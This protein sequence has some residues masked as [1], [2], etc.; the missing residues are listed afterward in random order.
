MNDQSASDISRPFFSIWTEP[1]ATIQH[2]IDSDPER[3]VLVL[4]AIGGAIEALNR[5]SSRS[6]GDEL[7]MGA[8]FMIAL[9]AGSIGGILSLYVVAGLVGWT[10]R[11]IGGV[12]TYKQIRAAIAWSF[13]PFL[14]VSLMWIPELLVFGEEMFTTEMPR[15]EA[16]PNLAYLLLAMV[17]VEFVGIIW[18]FV[19]YLHCLGQVQHFSAWRALGNVVIAALI[20]VV[21]TLVVVMAIYS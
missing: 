2:I 13:V 9:I 1:R 3:L 12:A 8:I 14:W 10:G 5:A 7:G 4:A 20:V 21:P 6:V 15:L 19:V 17:G 11:W 16:N 18:A